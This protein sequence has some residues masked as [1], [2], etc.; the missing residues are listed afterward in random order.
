MTIVGRWTGR[1]AK[2]LREALRLSVR[3]FAAY[4]GVAVRTVN[5]WEA[6]LADITPLPHMQEVL[7]TALARASDEAKA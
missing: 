6:R 4:L 2:L 5:E 7:D 3:G 1:E